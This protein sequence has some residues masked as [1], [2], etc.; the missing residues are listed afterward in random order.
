[1]T[2][3]L[4]VTGWG[5]LC[6]AGIGQDALAAVVA[7]RKAD[8]PVPV[9]SLYAA[10]LPTIAAHAVTGLDVRKL[11][12]RRG[13]SF[14]DRCTSL[15]LVAS[16]QALADSGMPVDDGTRERIGVTLATT[17]GSLQSS[18]A[19][20]M[21]TLVQDRPYLVNP[22]LFPNTVMNCAAGQAAIWFGLKGTNTTIA[23]GQ[24]AF[25]NVL[26]YAESVLRNGYADG[27]LAGAVEEYT[28]SSAWSVWRNSGVVAGEG[29][30]VFL[31]EPVEQARAARRFVHAEVLGVA[32]G[33]SPDPD[34]HR[35]LAGCVR[36]ALDTCG[37][38][39][40]AVALVATG[41][42]GAEA[43]ADGGPADVQRRAV[44]A[45]LGRGDCDELF[46]KDMFGECQAASAAL[47]AASVLAVHR[48]APERDGRLAVITACTPEGG[49]G[50]AVLRG[51]SRDGTDHR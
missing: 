8:E 35:A 11:L 20:S 49:V 14:F 12:G 17:A 24:V 43:A 7:R 5:A 48:D 33:F 38:D 26:K 22:V 32:V 2:H 16:G 36:R 31:V 46:V 30:A 27:I 29:A 47:Q 1:M 23:S 18:C 15:A 50:A 39:S 4:A 6:S 13:T 25:L 3:V 41:A 28:P 9:D 45:A 44:R 34:D 51:W 10:P 37:A 19:Y 40:A 21:E 42:A